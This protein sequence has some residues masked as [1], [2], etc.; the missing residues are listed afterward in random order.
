MLWSVGL[1]TEWNR[2]IFPIRSMLLLCLIHRMGFNGNPFPLDPES[3][4]RV[5][6]FSIRSSIVGKKL[7]VG[8]LTYN[9]NESDLEALF[10]PFGSVQSAQV[11]VDRDTN[12]SKGFGF[13]EMGSDA[14]AQAAIQ[15]L[16]GHDHDGRNLTVNEAKPREERGGGGG[17]GGY[18][19]GRGGGGGGGYGGGG[20]GGG[21]RY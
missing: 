12:R 11:I 17:R 9:V 18:G 20:G 15:A 10:S 16:N 3:I 6:S 7:Y 5:V 1:T 4:T 8:N 21:R 14:E 13:V 2:W 19:G